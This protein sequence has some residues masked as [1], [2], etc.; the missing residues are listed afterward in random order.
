MGSGVVAASTAVLGVPLDGAGVG[1][2]ATGVVAA[3]AG[4]AA[5]EV[6]FNPG[7]PRSGS[8]LLVLE[9]RLRL[10]QPVAIQ[11]VVTRTY[12]SGIARPALRPFD[13]ILFVGSLSILT[14]FTHWLD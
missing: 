14:R 3:G 2:T 6:G 1:K 12:A 11:N 7:P 4:A 8:G 5:A 13:G 10:E 9:L